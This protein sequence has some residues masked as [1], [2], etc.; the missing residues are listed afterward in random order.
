MEFLP[1]WLQPV[2]RSLPFSYIYW[3]PAKLFVN[4]SHALAL[5][6]LPIQAAWTGL[7]VA[8]ALLCYR[9]GVRRLQVN[10]G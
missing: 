10:G 4:Y 8:L 9:L 1:V 6:L 3:A 2:A 7:A 5:E